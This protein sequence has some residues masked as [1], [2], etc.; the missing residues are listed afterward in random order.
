MSSGWSMIRLTRKNLCK[1]QSK[2][3]TSLRVLP[4]G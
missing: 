3:M 1:S 2:G 4:C